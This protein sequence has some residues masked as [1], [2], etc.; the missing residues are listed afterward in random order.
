MNRPQSP[1]KF[2]EAIAVMEGFYAP[3]SRPQRNNNPGDIS[4]GNFASKHGATGPETLASGG[5]GRFAV[6]PSPEVGFAAMNALLSGPSYQGMTVAEALNKW[7]P[8]G[9]GNNESAYLDGVC[10]MT[11]CE[12]DTMIDGLL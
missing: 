12:P 8:P 3:G 4:W 1:M 9:D 7:A 6:F 5:A 11:G 10:Q 2:V